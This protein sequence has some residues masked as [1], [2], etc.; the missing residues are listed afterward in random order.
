MYKIAVYPGSFDPVTEGH[1]DILKRTSK[2]FSKVIMAVVVNQSKDSLFTIEER[3][4][5]LRKSINLD[6]VEFDSFDGLLVDYV[7]QKKGDV[8]I[9]GLRATTDFEYEFQMAHTNK[10]LAGDIETMFIAA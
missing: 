5:I 2:M 9:R 8:I 7:R 10:K 3:L 1:L 6:N 4:D